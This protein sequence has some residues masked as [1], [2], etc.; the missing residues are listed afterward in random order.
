LKIRSALLLTPF[1]NEG[2]KIGSKAAILVTAFTK[3]F[4]TKPATSYVIPTPKPIPFAAPLNAGPS[5]GNNPPITA[6]SLP[7]LT[8]LENLAAANSFPVFP[9]SF[10]LLK[11]IGSKKKVYG[12][13][14]WA[15]FPKNQKNNPKDHFLQW[16]DL[17][18]KKKDLTFFHHLIQ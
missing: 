3:G 8:L 17:L 2:V 13:D 7:N 9:S 4:K 6:P 10:V 12:Y 16:Q 1:I 15:G 5:K 11:K 14:S 18:Q